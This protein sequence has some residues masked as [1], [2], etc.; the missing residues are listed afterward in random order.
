M[1]FS[2]TEMFTIKEKNKGMPRES[3]KWKEKQ[4]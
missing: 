3:L 4:R 1:R 2:L